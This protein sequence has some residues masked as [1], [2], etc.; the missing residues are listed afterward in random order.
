ME[1]KEMFYRKAEWAANHQIDAARHAIDEG[2]LNEEQINV[3]MEVASIRHKLHSMSAS[4]VY[5]AES[6]AHDEFMRR[7]D[8]DGEESIKE[9]VAG[10]GL[11]A[12]DPVS[13]TEFAEIPNS[14]DYDFDNEGFD[15][16][17]EYLNNTPYLD[18]LA[19]L[20]ERFNKAIEDY[21]ASIDAEYGTGFCP[22]GHTRI[23]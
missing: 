12:F 16:Y 3:L 14:L 5:N 21:L 20:M 10:C 13:R 7:I 9:L 18:R 15:S 22:G 23:F 4:E 17:E 8:P 6:P 1:K 19:E 2:S 11:P